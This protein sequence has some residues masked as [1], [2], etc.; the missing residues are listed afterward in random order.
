[1]QKKSQWWKEAIVYQIYI[2]SFQDSNNDGIGDIKGIQFRLD[3]LKDLGINTIWICPFYKSPMHDNGYDISDYQDIN[4]L[5]GSM[6]DFDE[7]LKEAH[8]RGIK[9]IVDLVI[10]HTSNEHPWFIE[11]RKENNS[12]KRDWYIWRKGD[13]NNKPNNWESIFGGSVWKYDHN[14]DEYYLHIF[15]SKQPDLNWENKDVR[16]ALY[17]II[18][19]WI[20]K[21]VDGFRIDAISHIKKVEGLP[22]LPNPNNFKYVPSYKMHMNVSGID[23]FLLELK[24]NINKHPNIMT[25]GEANG[26]TVKDAVTW[27]HDD[28]G[29]MNMIFQFEQYEIKPKDSNE[30]MDVVGFK[31]ILTKWQNAFENNGWNAL[32]IENHDK[33]RSISL[34]GVDDVK[35]HQKCGKAFALMYFMMK[36]TPFIYQGQE[37]GM[38]NVRFDN[39]NDYKDVAALNLYKFKL[40]EGNTKESILREIWDNGRD[41]ARTPMQWSTEPNA[42]FTKGIPWLK[43]NPNYKFINVE[44]QLQDK[45]SILNFYKKLI[46][47][48]KSDDLFIHGSFKL[49]AKNHKQV[50]AYSRKLGNKKAYIIVNMTKDV[51]IYYVKGKEIL[52]SDIILS[53][54]DNLIIANSNKIKLR[55]FEA[56]L[57]KN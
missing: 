18:N 55:P 48:R 40:Q 19:W 7:L 20:D 31:K 56:M 35:F 12:P 29:Y 25:V 57:L 6:V 4:E 26:V 32:Y 17:E 52:G 24:A 2:Q 33:P 44:D 45:D 47:I 38:T 34:W 15:S 41:N 50:F 23:K 46:K 51:A 8:L 43:V 11:S 54:Y 53:N 10:N 16:N 37:I 21:G 22:N 49:L 13:K 42:G 14:T 28:D 27:V 9:V 1:M 39:I 30:W 36:G 5:F 3:Y